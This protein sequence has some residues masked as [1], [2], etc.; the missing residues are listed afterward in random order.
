M[1]AATVPTKAA[2]APGFGAPARDRDDVSDDANTPEALRAV[3]RRRSALAAYA[4]AMTPPHVLAF[5]GCVS[6]CAQAPA[7]PQPL[8]ELASPIAELTFAIDA[9]PSATAPTSRFRLLPARD[10]SRASYSSS[11][12]G[13]RGGARRG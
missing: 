3:R 13:R 1:G 7:Y 11:L 10:C 2:G 6:T 8:V 4:H 5:I 12:G 9:S